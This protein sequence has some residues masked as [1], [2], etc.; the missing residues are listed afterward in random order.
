MRLVELNPEIVKHGEY[1]HL[2]FKCPKCLSADLDTH[3]EIPLPPHPKAWRIE[4]G[5]ERVWSFDNLTLSPSIDFKHG[6]WSSEDPAAVKCN[7]HFFVRAGVIE[8]C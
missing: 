3:V 5:P 8:M 2:R 6:D 1:E 4:S 7:A